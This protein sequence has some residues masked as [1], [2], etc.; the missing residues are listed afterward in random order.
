MTFRG[1]LA[2]KIAKFVA[3]LCLKMGRQGVTWAGLIA[4][5]IEP[6]ILKI[7]SDQIREKVY[8]VCGTNGKTTTN[9]MLCTTLQNQGKK[10]ICNRTGSNMLNGVVSA[11][12]LATDDNCTLD[13]D[14]ACIEIDEVS[15][16]RVL[17]TLKP[18]YMVLTNIFRDQL[19][20]YGEIDITINIL[21]TAIKMAPNMTLVI[22]GDDPLSVSLAK[23]SGNSFITYGI[24]EKVFDA[25]E[26]AE[27]REG[28]FCT[29]CGAKMHY[30]YYHY[31][32][33]GDYSCPSCGFARPE[34]DYPATEIECGDHLAFTVDN[35]KIKARYKGFYNIYN[36]LAVYAVA[37]HSGVDISGFQTMLDNFNP[38]NGR[39]EH[40]I[41]KETDIELNLAKN[42]AGFNQNINAVMAD[43]KDKD[44]IILI[45]DRD[46]D[47]N[48][49]SWLWD[50]D[51][52]QFADSSIKS[53][54]VS[55]IRCQDM[56]LRLK[57]VDIQ[58]HL[59][60]N[61]EKAIQ[62]KINNG[63]KNLYV[64]VNY[65]GLYS[66]RNILKRME[67]QQ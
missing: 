44:I 6:N 9:N 40:F 62:E 39:I 57:Y 54:T 33:L 20:R 19:D 11:F 51:F 67:G 18:D 56:R 42:P 2:I 36:I 35:K 17:P 27:I 49:V 65:T 66:T 12:V 31:S 34:I 41:I 21:G 55:G 25:D 43:P 24:S 52:D 29:M 47:G 64:L 59:E 3:K 10:V 63:V 45:N 22:N 61:I 37:Q 46:Q 28:R 48:D 14:Y 32:Q 53:I 58:S 16:K 50:V 60:P 8:I 4:R 7:L 30:N 23:K 1:K 5:K 13:A 38:E 26:N 15:T